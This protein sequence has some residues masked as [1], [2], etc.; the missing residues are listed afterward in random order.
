MVERVSR[1][2]SSASSSSTQIDNSLAIGSEPYN[3][4][5]AARQDKINDDLRERAR[6]HASDPDGHH[7]SPED[8]A[9]EDADARMQARH[10][11]QLGEPDDSVDT[12]E[13]PHEDCTLSGESDRIGTRNFDDDTPFGERSVIV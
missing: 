7:K 2:S 13:E 10:A 5:V 9:E 4:W 6:E 3:A 8:E 1:I 12:A 11:R